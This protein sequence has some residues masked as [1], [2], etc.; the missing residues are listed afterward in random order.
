MKFAVSE[1]FWIIALFFV[2]NL[3]PEIFRDVLYSRLEAKPKTFGGSH[4][5]LY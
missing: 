2:L 4:D 3:N 5:K 1:N